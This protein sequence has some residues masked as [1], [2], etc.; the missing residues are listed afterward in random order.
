[1]STP[2]P[3][4]AFESERTVIKPS[5]ARRAARH[6]RRCPPRPA[7]EALPASWATSACSTRWCRPRAALLIGKLR[8]LVPLANVPAPAC[9]PHRRGGA[10]VRCR[11]RGAAG[12]PN[13]SVLAARRILCTALDEAVANTHWGVRAG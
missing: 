5:R 11:P 2:D 8:N 9:L 1:M 13:E 4:A 7:S 3:F 10:A 12:V 6:R